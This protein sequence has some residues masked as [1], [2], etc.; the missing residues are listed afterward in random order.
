M[1]IDL[2]D[3]ASVQSFA[4]E[5]KNKYNKLDLLINNA[6]VMIPPYT[7]TKD[8]FELQMGT[9][10]F[11]HFALTLLL[12]D[13]IKATPNSRIVNV[14]SAAHKYGNINF[15]DLNWENRKYKSWRAYGDSK[16]ANLYFTK[17]LAAKLDKVIVTAAHPG[18]T[19][20]DLQRHSGLFSYLNKFFAMNREQG[21]LPT[22]RAA[23]DENAKSGDYFGPDGWQEWKGFPI[24][25]YTNKLAKDTSV[26]KKLWDVSEE[27]TNVKFNHN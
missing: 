6:G 25:V 1:K 26:A 11:G 20:T 16:I 23:I 10:H 12:L 24:K 3:L 27:L 8:G 7:K 9:N 14:A 21:A 18:W 19:A 15:D 22:L 5:Y 13:T 17:E 2:S 4:E